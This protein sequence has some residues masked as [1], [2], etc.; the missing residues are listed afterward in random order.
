LL[1]PPKRVLCVEDNQDICFLLYTALRGQGY[2]TVMTYTAGDALM[3]AGREEF[4]LFILD[5]V[6]GAESCIELCR[7]LRAASPNTPVVFYSAAA[8]DKDREAALRAG[9][10]AYVVKPGM[11]ELVEAVSRALDAG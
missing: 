4:D 3:L 2:E 7:A 5:T 10:C 6:L 11:D 8:F 9:A 1:Q